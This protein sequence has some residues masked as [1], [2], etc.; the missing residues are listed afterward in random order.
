MNSYCILIFLYSPTKKLFFCLRF[1][2]NNFFNIFFRKICRI[3][4][5]HYIC[6]RNRKG[7]IGIGPWCNGNTP[8][9]G[10]VIQ[11]SSPCGPTKLHLEISGVFLFL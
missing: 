10:T 1:P 5:M 7:C 6:T 9:F 11:G 2:F 8:V 3:K 4:N